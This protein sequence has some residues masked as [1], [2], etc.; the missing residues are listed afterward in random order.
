[1]RS[2]RKSIVLVFAVVHLVGGH[3]HVMEGHARIGH[4][5]VC[6]QGGE[7]ALNSL[8]VRDGRVL[9]RRAGGRGNQETT[10]A[11]FGEAARRG[12]LAAAGSAAEKPCGYLD[13]AGIFGPLG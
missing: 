9:Q 8:R 5:S 10:S 11:R 3:E 7:R 1:M 4:S 6:R 13:L 2:S 12:Q